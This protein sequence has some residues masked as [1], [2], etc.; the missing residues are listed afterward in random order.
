LRIPLKCDLPDLA[1]STEVSLVKC[2]SSQQ[3][4]FAGTGWRFAVGTEDGFSI[5]EALRLGEVSGPGK[6]GLE[7]AALD[8]LTD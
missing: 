7:K 2:D 8:L 3:V 6:A 4:E 1:G 5:R